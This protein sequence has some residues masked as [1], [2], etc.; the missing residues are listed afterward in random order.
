MEL[1][2]HFCVHTF[3]NTFASVLLMLYLFS[4]VHDSFLNF[5]L[6]LLHSLNINTSKLQFGTPFHLLFGNSATYDNSSVFGTLG[7]QILVIIL[8]INQVQD[9]YIGVGVSIQHCLNFIFQC[10]FG[11]DFG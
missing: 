8:L 10:I 5:G 4:T 7:I 6:E 1:Y 11:I 9:L 3:I 2:L